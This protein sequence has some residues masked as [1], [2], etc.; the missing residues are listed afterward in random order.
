MSC[1]SSARRSRTRDP[2]SSRSGSPRRSARWRGVAPG[3]RLTAVEPVA[4][5]HHA[6]GAPQDLDVEPH[7]AML[8]VPEVE[9]D[10]LVPREL[11]APVDLRP[12]GD[13]G[14]H[15]QAPALALG[16]AVDLHRD[17]RPRPD[18]RHV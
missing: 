10:A 6:G 3:W 15:G 2:S 18:D 1:A 14:L 5:E 7:G 16:V 17:G 13:A 4:T 12:P 11:R 8:D 9:L